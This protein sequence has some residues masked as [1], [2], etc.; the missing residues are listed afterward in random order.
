MSIELING[1]C[2]IEM[3]KIPDK[4]I[5]LV[6]TDPPYGVT[7]NRQ[8]VSVDLTELFRVGKGVIMTAQQP[9][10]TEVIYKFK[11]YFKYDLVWDKVLTSGFLNANRMP[12]R[13]HESILVFNEVCYNPQKIIGN[14]NHSKGRPK[15]SVNNNYGKHNFVDNTEKLGEMK[16]PSSIVTFS[17][18]HP[19]MAYHRTEKSIELMK[20][21]INTYSKINDTILDP[22]MGSGTTGVA[23]KELNRN[24]IGIEIDKTYYELSKKRI[25]ETIVSEKLYE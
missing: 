5:D 12:L 4:S 19:S 3:K 10:T 25:E 9:Y 18:P 21:L 16:H 7:Q 20:W 2:L 6:L 22:F 13:R 14:K 17:K 24:F 11:G 23:C 15:E 8:D 1:D